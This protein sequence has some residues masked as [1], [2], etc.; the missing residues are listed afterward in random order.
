[1]LE[2]SA[3][4]SS[5]QFRIKVFPFSHIHYLEFL[6]LNLWSY[7]FYENIKFKVL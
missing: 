3:I 7:T 6:F 1:M 4:Y 5:V 2:Y